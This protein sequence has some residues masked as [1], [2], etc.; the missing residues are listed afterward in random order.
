MGKAI[1]W[2]MASV[3]DLV[4]GLTSNLAILESKAFEVVGVEEL[5]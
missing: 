3:D 5:A 4:T 1:E 2:L